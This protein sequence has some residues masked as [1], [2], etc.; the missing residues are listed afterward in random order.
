MAY[1]CLLIDDD[2]AAL[3]VMELYLAKIPS[4][5]LLGKCENAIEAMDFLRNQ[6]VDLMVLDIE[7]PHLTG[8]DFLKTLPHPPKA[9]ITSANKEYALEG[10][11]L[12]V[13][14][15]ILKPV[16][17]ER[18]MKAINR[19]L[20]SETSE[21]PDHLPDEKIE[22]GILYL[23]ENKKMV[24]LHINDILY[25]ESLKDYVKVYARDKNVVTKQTLQFF[26]EKLPHETF[27]RIHKSFIVSVTNIEAFSASTI[28]IGNKELPIGRMYK[29]FVLN[30][31]NQ[32]Y[33]KA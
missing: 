14:D 12:N 28:E 30:F 5:Q 7:M 32:N 4:F 9:I 33:S 3:A 21:T 26:E 11:E 17:F 6:T 1:K 2:P 8:I 22:S 29:D 27:L 16:S 13:L 25:I 20:S 18:F 19:F 31:L 10:F 24:K 15:Y 23:K